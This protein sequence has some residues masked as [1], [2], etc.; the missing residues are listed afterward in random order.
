MA[1]TPVVTAKRRTKSKNKRLQVVST[2][3]ASPVE[4]GYITRMT[5]TRS[6]GKQLHDYIRRGSGVGV[7]QDR[8]ARV[9]IRAAKQWNDSVLFE[10][11]LA[12]DDFSENEEV[13]LAELQEQVCASAQAL[14]YKLKSRSVPATFLKVLKEAIYVAMSSELERTSWPFLEQ[15]RALEAQ[16]QLDSALD[17]IYASIDEL[18]RTDEIDELMRLLGTVAPDEHSTDCLIAILTATLP[19]KSKL[20]LRANF[21]VAVEN[22]LSK[23]GE[24]E[25]DL[26]DGLS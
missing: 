3:P 13:E 18:L 11:P 22:T 21:Y 6:T 8:E 10:R 26:L 20:P 1:N 9:F 23:R 15:A 19:A 12:Y 24:L 5:G 17:V 25:P 14:V 4:R 7:V 2:V 16:G